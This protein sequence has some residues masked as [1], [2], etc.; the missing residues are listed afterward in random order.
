MNDIF[1]LRNSNVRFFTDGVSPPPSLR[2]VSNNGSKLVFSFIS[3][4]AFQNDLGPD[5]SMFWPTP[6]NVIRSVEL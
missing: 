5:V 2:K 6:K 3:F 1:E 4:L